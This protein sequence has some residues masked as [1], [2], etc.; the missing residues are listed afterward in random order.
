MLKTFDKFGNAC[1][2]GGLLPQGRLTVV[3]QG[4]A[5]NTLLMPNNHQVTVDDLG[6]GTYAARIQIKIPAS[7]KLIV[8]MDK[9]LIKRVSCCSTTHVREPARTHERDETSHQES[10]PS[11][12]RAEHRWG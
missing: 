6:D 3:K 5:D 11:Q 9:N 7:V 2:F 4:V 10:S 1:T 12:Q 8:N